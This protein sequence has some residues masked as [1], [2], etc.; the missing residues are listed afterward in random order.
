MYN[1]RDIAGSILKKDKKS[2]FN[3]ASNHV[4][5]SVCEYGIR[6]DD[7]RIRIPLVLFTVCKSYDI[8]R[9]F[10]VCPHHV[11]KQ[12]GF[13]CYNSGDGASYEQQTDILQPYIS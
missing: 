13:N 2:A 8:Y 11:L 6:N 9:G 12:Y 3:K 5:L 7:G 1:R 4:Q 10:S